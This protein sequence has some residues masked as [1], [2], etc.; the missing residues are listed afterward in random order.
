MTTPGAARVE[1]GELLLYRL[2]D[3][4][5]AIDL[6]KAAT[7]VQRGET[8]RLDMRRFQKNQLS[9]S[10][11]PLHYELGQQRVTIDTQEVSVDSHVRIFDFG[12]LS[13][14]LKVEL[15]QKSALDELV[16]WNARL[17]DHPAMEALARELARQVHDDLATASLRPKFSG[18]VEDYNLLFV[19]QFDAPV[20]VPELASDRAMGRLLLA[21]PPGREIAGEALDD[22]RAMAFS[23][24]ADE[25]AVIDYN[26]AFVYDPS[27]D[28]SIPDLIEFASAQLLELRYYDDLLDRALADMYDEIE[29][30]RGAARKKE[31]RLLTRKLLQVVLE[32]TELTE[33]IEN[34]LKWVGD[35][36]LAKVYQAAAAQ[37]NLQRW[38]T[39]VERKV[40]LV[41]KVTELLSD[42]INT[43]RALF[44]ETSIVILILIE[45]VAA[46]WRT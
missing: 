9:I 1:R 37:F 39:Q 40:N 41:T 6:D 33:K 14:V 26:S 25:L 3:V 36:Y 2:F 4:A 38:Q 43:D 18:F 13:V 31:V 44:L 42:Q 22:A 34:S 30:V 8:R 5:D 21:E 24:Y 15:P 45:I 23:Y 32:V 12:V 28:A 19:R 46:F 17:V 20:A 35:H 7:R 11:P 27:G 29:R 16:G 10:E